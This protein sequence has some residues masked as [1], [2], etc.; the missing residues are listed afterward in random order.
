FALP[1]LRALIMLLLYWGSRLFGIKLSLKCW[2]LLVLFFIILLSPFSLISSSFWLSVY[3][4]V[5]ILLIIWRHGHQLSSGH[6]SSVFNKLSKFTKSLFLIQ[7]SLTLAM[8]PLAAMFNHQ[9]SLVSFFAN[10]IAVPVMSFTSI[11]LCLLA[12]FV[13]PVSQALSTFFL[14]L[15]VQSLALVWQWLSF[16]TDFQWSVINL[17]SVDIIV[18]AVFVFILLGL[19][20]VIL[21]RYLIVFILVSL[22]MFLLIYFWKGS[23][24][25]FWHT[26]SNTQSD[27]VIRVM[28]VGQGLAIIIEQNNHYILYDTG[29]SYPSGFNMADAVLSPY[30]KHRGIKVLDKVIISHSDNDHSGSLNKLKQSIN[31]DEIIANDKMLKADSLCLQGQ[32]FIWQGLT[33]STFWPSAGKS[34]DFGQNND[35]SCVIKI[36]DG[37][38]SVLL[39]G[40]ISKKV[41]RQL[42]INHSNH[43][44]DLK[45]NVLIAPHHGS[46]TSSTIGFINRVSP[47]IVVFSS[48]YL[49]RWHM[50]VTEVVS[51]YQRANVTSFNTAIS[52]MIE[53]HINQQGVEV[54]QYR[55]DL[56]PFWFS[57]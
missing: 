48:G 8:L 14:Q 18:L 30:F 37:K 42:L 22:I 41:E 10:I 2:V 56:W 23:A 46:K 45:S 20:L 57:N 4:V 34:P 54:K 39:T 6:S 19:W 36:T 33:F 1:T 38:F 35:D 51:R 7:I 17:S 50:P 16:L 5:I 53:I 27:W 40:D 55:Q 43:Q 31:I 11:P 44:I 3:A 47:E 9:L 29:A 13:L 21:N 32:E 12:V 15:A 49:N 24:D 28:D 52:G 26:S 25:F